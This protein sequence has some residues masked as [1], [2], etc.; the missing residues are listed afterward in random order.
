MTT[1]RSA[2]RRE[3]VAAAGAVALAAPAVL[4]A[5]SLNSKLDVAII[6]CG[7]AGPV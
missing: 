7:G 3:F 2:S 1:S 6:G 5:Q 4:R